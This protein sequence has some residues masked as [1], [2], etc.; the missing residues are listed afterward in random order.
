MLVLTPYC[1][2]G[3]WLLILTRYPLTPVLGPRFW[4]IF[5]HFHHQSSSPIL[6]RTA[7]WN[8]IKGGMPPPD[9]APNMDRPYKPWVQAFTVP[10]GEL[11]FNHLTAGLKLDMSPWDV[12]GGEGTGKWRWP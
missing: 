4:S 2:V 8:K 1:E 12:K 3:V 5:T 7:L 11:V 9:M 6:Q 10:G